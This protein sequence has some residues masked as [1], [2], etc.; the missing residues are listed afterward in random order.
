ME[1]DISD[2]LPILRIKIVGFYLKDVVDRYPIFSVRIMFETEKK[3][4]DASYP[5][6][7]G[8]TIYMDDK[9]KL[10]Y[11]KFTYN[12]NQ[13]GKIKVNL[14]FSHGT[15]M[16]KDLWTYYIRRIFTDEPNYYIGCCIAFDC[17]SHGDSAIA[18]KGKL[19]WI[20][21]AIDGGRDII[22]IIENEREVDA[23]L[24]NETNRTILIGHSLGAQQLVF[25]SYLNGN[26]FDTIVLVDPII[27][28]DDQFQKRYASNFFKL[29]NFIE[30]E[31]S[32]KRD[33]EL[34]FSERSFIKNFND[35]VLKDVIDNEVYYD[36]EEDVFRCKSSKVSQMAVY[37]YTRLTIKDTHVL[38]PLLNNKVFYLL[39]AKSP[40]C[41]QKV[42]QF[43]RDNVK[44]LVGCISVPNAGHLLNGEQPDIVLAILKDLIKKVGEDAFKTKDS[45]PN[46]S[47]SR[48]RI[49]NDRLKI[50]NEGKTEE[51]IDFIKSHL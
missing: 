10:V 21:A 7:P 39:A 14:I 26:L 31:F 13:K 8:S 2:F 50:F 22:K 34:F 33:A 29:S 40:Y 48:K 20:Y 6:T 19:G 43:I 45:Y 37:G 3:T 36:T 15:G 47:L 9:L 38:L 25:A 16:N 51:S 4:I 28:S 23:F 30:D 44:N 42:N 35:E 24:N 27:Y 41:T 18:N 17:V 32:S 11:T 1:T 12:G 5:R 46:R 49:L